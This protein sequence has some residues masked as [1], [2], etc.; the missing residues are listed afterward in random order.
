MAW[1]NPLVYFWVPFFQE[2]LR[3]PPTHHFRGKYP[4]PWAHFLK[5]LSSMVYSLCGLGWG[6]H[7]KHQLIQQKQL[8]THSSLKF[9]TVLYKRVRMFG[10]NADPSDVLCPVIGI[11]CWSSGLKMMFVQEAPNADAQ[12][13]WECRALALEIGSP[14]TLIWGN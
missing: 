7:G 14:M 4:Q 5:R 11:F 1:F 6:E 3:Y 9:F 10:I 12:F 8:D 2:G 13:L